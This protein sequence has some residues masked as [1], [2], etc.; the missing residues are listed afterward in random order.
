M[1]KNTRI[2][3]VIVFSMISFSSFAQ[4][5]ENKDSLW[6]HSPKNIIRY[7]F[8]SAL[9]F[10]FDK[11][12][13]LGYERL[14]NPRQSFSVNFGRAGLP[15]LIAIF[16]DSFNITRDIKNTGFHILA[17]YRF[18][19]TNE[20]RYATPHGFY[21]GPYYSFNRIERTNAWEGNN[22]T[23]QRKVNTKTNLDVHVIGFELG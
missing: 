23:N 16:T 13:I 14:V 1:K 9:L 17:D 3:V 10:G 8:S 20:N 5:L 7:N 11:A 12:V 19:L 4:M 6:K 22:S 21:I 18:Y 15:K 2:I